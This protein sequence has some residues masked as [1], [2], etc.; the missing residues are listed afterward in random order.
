MRALTDWSPLATLTLQPSSAPSR[1]HHLLRPV[2][3][4]ATFTSRL[5]DTPPASA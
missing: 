2:R 1:R 4:K 3:A 5:L